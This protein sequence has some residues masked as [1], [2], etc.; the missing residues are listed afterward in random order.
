MDQAVDK[1]NVEDE[2]KSMFKGL[3]N[4][5]IKN[6]ETTADGKIKPTAS[7]LKQVQRTSFIK[8]TLLNDAYLAKVEE[9]KGTFGEVAVMN[10]EYINA[11]FSG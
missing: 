10:E 11:E 2:E 5:L 1:L 6:I 8:K 3:R 9:F 7:N 4:F